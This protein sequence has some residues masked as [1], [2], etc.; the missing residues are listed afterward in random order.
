MDVV[1]RQ[2]WAGLRL[3][4]RSRSIV[5]AIL[6]IGR[7]DRLRAGGISYIRRISGPLLVADDPLSIGSKTTPKI[8]RVAYMPRHHPFTRPTIIAAANLL[9][10]FT[11]SEFDNLML[12]FGLE[13]KIASGN[14]VSRQVKANELSRVAVGDEPLMVQT[15]E[16]AMS[17]QEAMVR[18]AMTV[19]PRAWRGADWAVFSSGLKR[20]GFLLVKDED[21]R[22]FQLQ[23]MLPEVADL[24]AA[25]DDV[26]MHLEK[27]GFEVPLGHLCQAINAHSRGDWAASNSQLRT[28]LEGLLDQIAERLVPD[29]A[30]VTQ[31]GHHRRTLLASLDPPFLSRT[32]NE[33]RDDQKAGL[34]NGLFNRL[35]PEG[36]HPGLSDEEDSTFR[37]H[38]VI[39]VARLFLRRFVND[40]GVT[41][42]AT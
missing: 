16:G 18:A 32:L 34:V 2:I 22:T 25:S 11:H 4:S 23:R 30:S 6:L 41:S 3:I 10:D 38:I 17:L 8:E 5:K 13:T 14:T 19:A 40:S 9:A 24:P 21:D 29:K 26:N 7:T 39:I 28:F 15:S 42:G 27:H 20:D 12:Q 36:S 31:T 33:W 35:H 37:L 1:L